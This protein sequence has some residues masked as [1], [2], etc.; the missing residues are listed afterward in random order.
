MHFMCFMRNWLHKKVIWDHI[1]KADRE[2][3]GFQK[4]LQVISCIVLL[5]SVEFCGIPF[6]FAHLITVIIKI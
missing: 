4:T 3:D 2:I 6:I 5:A 1:L